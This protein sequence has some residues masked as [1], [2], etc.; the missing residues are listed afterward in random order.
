MGILTVDSRH[1]QRKHKRVQFDVLVSRTADE[2]FVSVGQIDGELDGFI[3]IQSLKAE[4][5]QTFANSEGFN[6]IIRFSVATQS[7]LDNTSIFNIETI[8]KGLWYVQ[9]KEVYGTINFVTPFPVSLKIT[10]GIRT[11]NHKSQ[12]TLIETFFYTTDLDW[13]KDSRPPAPLLIK[14]EK[15]ATGNPPHPPSQTID[16]SDGITFRLSNPAVKP[17][18][19]ELT[20]Y[21]IRIYSDAFQ[22]NEVASKLNL[23]K[24]QIIDADYIVTS[25][26]QLTGF[27]NLERGRKYYVRIIAKYLGLES[28]PL[29]F[30]IAFGFTAPSLSDFPSSVE[31]P[32]ALFF[33]GTATR[34][35]ANSNATQAEF[36]WELNSIP[37]PTVTAV[38]DQNGDAIGSFSISTTL[39]LIRVRA[40]SI[41][42]VVVGEWSDYVEISVIEE[43]FTLFIT[44]FGESTTNPLVLFQGQEKN[45]IADIN[46]TGNT[47][48]TIENAND[49]NYP[50]G[51]NLPT[52]TTGRSVLVNTEV[53][54]LLK[55]D[56]TFLIRGR[57][58]QSSVQR[59]ATVYVR[60]KD[61]ADLPTNDRLL[62]LRA[63]DIVGLSNGNGVSEW[64][65]YSRSNF[66]YISNPSNRPAKFSQSIATNQ[67]TYVAETAVGNPFG[68]IST[69]YGT[70]SYPCVYFYHGASQMDLLT[71]ANQ[72]TRF[73]QF[74]EISLY[75]V[76]SSTSTI[77]NKVLL[78]D[79]SLI[80]PNRA[81]TGLGEL[82]GV[83]Y[84][85]AGLGY[86][87]FPFSF[88]SGLHSPR[89]NS[90]RWQAASLP[91][92]SPATSNTVLMQRNRT[93]GAD[94][95]QQ[96]STTAQ[97]QGT[98]IV[99]WS[100]NRLG[101]D[102]DNPSSNIAT[103]VYYLA[104]LIIFGRY[105]TNAENIQVMNYLYAKY[106]IN[107]TSH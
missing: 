15:L 102:S 91:P 55:N 18:L 45:V 63:E 106:G 82:A 46:R 16:L 83:G 7:L 31:V 86:E 38:Y 78:C 28:P 58:P 92:N 73:P 60:V 75:I 3:T 47:L 44:G 99:N 6:N 70:K 53:G 80:A 25:N 89:V 88:Y 56:Y 69:P 43:D 14:P 2:P 17:I 10:A 72:P 76:Y 101:G 5:S 36:E 62:W 37:Q 40:R 21:D 66:D 57:T 51:K 30:A 93:M 35:T 33:Q 29:D 4:G 24:S 65:L 59:N 68:N 20:L 81:L 41:N 48:I 71:Q 105:L 13:I 94:I 52:F 87:S 42:N 27:S 95:F 22:Q 39:G 23:T 74:S 100:M 19:Q 1:M 77:A 84:F 107:P 8:D 32:N 96:G 34:G 79:T 11:G 98:E 85:S 90:V 9:F 104:E 61:I 26:T 103:Y 64:Y 97:F 50:R 12:S 54:V 49:S 67:P